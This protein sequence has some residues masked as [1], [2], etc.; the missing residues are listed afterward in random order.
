[1]DAGTSSLLESVTLKTLHAQNFSRS[2]TRA[3]HVLTDLLSRYMSLLMTTCARYAE[4][5]GRT[6][7]S[8]HD[9]FLALNELGIT[10][11]ELV[12]Y[13]DGEAHELSRYVGTTSRRAEELAVLK[14]WLTLY[15]VKYV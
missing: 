7:V 2:S 9:A 15:T 5:A 13:A 4:H 11:D 8:V 1:M 14:G 3:S 12:D 6:T 10:V